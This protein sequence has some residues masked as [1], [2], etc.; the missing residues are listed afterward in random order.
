MGTKFLDQY[1]LLHFAIGI[2]MYF[3]GISSFNWNMIHILFELLENTETGMK[4][5]NNVFTIWPGGKNYA[6]SYINNVGDI[7]AGYLG[8]LF[9]YWLDNYGNK[10]DWFERH[11]TI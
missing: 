4:I 5:I 9:A 10:H 2:V 11:I 8:W 7:M 6:D 1:S 3:W